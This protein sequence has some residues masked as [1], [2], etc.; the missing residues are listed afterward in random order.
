MDMRIAAGLHTANF[1]DSKKFT[2]YFKM[3]WRLEV[4]HN[5]NPAPS[6]EFCCIIMVEMRAAFKRSWFF[7][8]QAMLVQS[9]TITGVPLPG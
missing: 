2:I 4:V 1:C 8:V 7:V 3:L 9:K 6:L 5:A